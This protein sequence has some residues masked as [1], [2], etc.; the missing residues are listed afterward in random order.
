MP[1]ALSDD[2]RGSLRS[3]ILDH[4]L[5]GEPADSIKDTTALI[6]SGIIPS[7]A[8]LELVTYIETRFPVRFQQDDLTPDRLDTIDMIVELM[9]ERLDGPRPAP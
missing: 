2:V 6:S 9:R 3:F 5:V 8:M 4:F 1:E 7:V